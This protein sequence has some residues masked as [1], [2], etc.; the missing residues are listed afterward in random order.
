MIE[1]INKRVKEIEM[2]GIRTFSYK[3]QEYKDVV[4]LTVGQPDFFTPKHIKDSG[5]FAIDENYTSY[6]HNSGFLELRKA[7]SSYINKKYQLSYN[8]LDEIIV[9]NGA[10]EGIDIAFRTIL[11]EGSEVILPGPI[12]PGYEP[13]IKLCG[14]IPVF[15]DTSSN[16]FKINANM[17]RCRI[18]EKTRCIVLS[19]PSNPMGTILKKDEL[20]EIANLLRDKQ[21]FI[22]SD[23]IY[24]ELTF[25]SH[26][27]SIAALPGMKEKTIIINGLAK[28][29][30]MTGWRIGFTFAPSYLSN[31]MLKVHAYNS[32]CASSISQKAA[33]TAL[34]T[35]I[36]D[37][38]EMMEEYGKRRDYAFNRLVSMGMEIVKPEG[39]FY[40]FPSIKK[41]GMKSYEFAI[42]LLET[43]GVA[44][45]PGDSFSIFGEG[46]IRISYAYSMEVLEKGLNRIEEFVKSQT[47]TCV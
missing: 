40:L 41:T 36:D 45:V 46:Y 31:E 32:V 35:G 4:D 20:I 15:V 23:E 25:D 9:T 12:Y 11:D 18:T 2:T 6:S 16:N 17:I 26:H 47:V 28:S 34:T 5:K 19:Y 33:I 13:L 8:P 27:I 37:P 1:F 21:I 30:S 14:A 29:H 44:V 22:I 3:V 10:S 43:Q 24:S 42:R 39:A 38:L 7:A